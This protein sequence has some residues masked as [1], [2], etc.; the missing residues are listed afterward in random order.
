MS[1]VRT[2]PARQPLAPSPRSSRPRV[3]HAPPAGRTRPPSWRSRP[4]ETFVVIALA[5]PAVLEYL[6]ID[7]A[8][9]DRGT[10]FLVD[11]SV[12][13]DE[14]VIP[15]VTSRKEVAVTNVQRIEVGQH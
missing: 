3:D 12:R 10:D 4:G 6:G 15:S 14:L 9:I 1:A 8:T 7:P 13:T 2:R 5:T 11:R